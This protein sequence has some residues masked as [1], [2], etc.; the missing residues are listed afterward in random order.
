L[1]QRDAF[2]RALDAQHAAAIAQGVS[3]VAAADTR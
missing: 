3:P 1:Q 2:Q